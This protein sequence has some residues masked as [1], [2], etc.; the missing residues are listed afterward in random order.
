VN[1]R[2]AF[3]AGNF[4]DCFKHALLL[5]LLRAM[6]RKEKPFLALDTHAGSGRYDLTSGPAERTGEWRQGIARLQAARPAALADYLGCIERLGLYP[7]SPAIIQALLRPG[8]RLIACELHPED[9]RILKSEFAGSNN[10]S[11]HARDGYAALRAFLPPEQKRAFILIDP[12]Y[13]QPDEFAVL[14]K[15]LDAA[16]RKFKTGVYAVWYP[17]KHQAPVR[18]FIETLKLTPIR[19]VITAELLLRQAVD[20]TRLN[21]CGLLVIN[22][23]YGFEDQ[24]QPILQAL[25]NVLGEAG[26][27]ARIERLIDE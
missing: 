19:D 26:S 25:Q 13:E 7:G 23:P 20:P 5:V 15:S 4:A 2:H 3:H 6:Q 27:A 24:A 22:P 16:Y 1:Y 18:N 8:D 17:I 11:V 10:I 12:P 14:A 9:A 21:G